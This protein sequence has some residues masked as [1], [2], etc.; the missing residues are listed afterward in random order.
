LSDNTYSKFYLSDIFEALSPEQNTALWGE[1]IRTAKPGAVVAY[2]N[3][4]VERTYP[5]DRSALFKTDEENLR[6]LRAKD[7]VFFY[8]RFFAHTIQK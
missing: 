6:K 4:L 7:R 1:I 5:P 3:N 2:W 8:D